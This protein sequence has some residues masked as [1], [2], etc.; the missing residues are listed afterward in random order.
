MRVEDTQFDAASN[1]VQIDTDPASA[2][3][4]VM[5]RGA[6]LKRGERVLASGRVLRSQELGALAEMGKYTI[7]A[8]R[9]PRVGV[10]ATGDELVPIDET[11]KAGQI[12]N[13][14]ETML[15]AQLRV[16][17]AEPVP[18]GI[19]RDER[20]HL[21]ERIRAGLECDM[22]LLSGGVSA[23][24]LDLVPS[25]LAAAG[26]RQVFHVVNL[27]PGKPLWFGVYDAADTAAAA[28]MLR[29]RVAGKPSQQYGLLRIVRPDGNSPPDGI[30]ERRA[31]VCSRQAFGRAQH[32]RQSADVSSRQA[33]VGGIASGC[34]AGGVAGIGRPE[35][36]SRRERDDRVSR[37]RQILRGG[38]HSRR[39]VVGPLKRSSRASCPRMDFAWP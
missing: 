15:V 35:S 31:A 14:N 3:R 27:K 25:E 12:R 17:G 30:R 37:R 23:G 39:R 2:L 7:R 34:R 8:R 10:L 4:S 13:S 22:L 16:A 33:D 24:K 32:P 26:V 18:L 9:R 28:A 6:S 1:T 38:R 11:P 21:A 19:A 29:F 20:A 36:D 5:R